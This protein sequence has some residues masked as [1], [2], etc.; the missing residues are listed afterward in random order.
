MILTF[1]PYNIF[2]HNK[3][4]HPSS[5]PMFEC[6]KNLLAGFLPAPLKVRRRIAEP[7]LACER[8]YLSGSIENR[9]W[10]VAGYRPRGVFVMLVD[11][12]TTSDVIRDAARELQLCGLDVAIVEPTGSG[13]EWFGKEFGLGLH[14]G[15][16]VDHLKKPL[17]LILS[18]CERINAKD[19]EY[20][21][22]DLACEGVRTNR[23]STVAI[24]RDP[25]IAMEISKYNF[26]AKFYEI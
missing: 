11:D 15:S 18:E 25:E 4:Y 9:L 3:I 22:C 24:V 21:L 23:L 19:R 7:L 14:D 13:S 5:S 17:L 10:H 8:R 12:W 1:N 2:V 16:L 6:T 26:G 20:F